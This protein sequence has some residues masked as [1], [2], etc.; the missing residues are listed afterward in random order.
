MCYPEINLFT[1][2]S[3]MNVCDTTNCVLI[4]TMSDETNICY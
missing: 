3:T 4:D 2:I 1:D